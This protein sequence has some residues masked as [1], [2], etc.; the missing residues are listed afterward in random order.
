MAS[1]MFVDDGS[2]T[3]DTKGEWVPRTLKSAPIWA[4]PPRPKAVFKFFFGFPGYLWPLGQ[5]AYW[6]LA[7]VTWLFLQPGADELSSFS[8]LRGS[9]IVPM[10]ARNVVLLLVIAGV[11]H[12]RLYWQRGQGTRFK[13]NTQWPNKKS[14]AFLFGNQVWDNMFWSVVSGAGIWTIYE[15]LM[16]WAYGNGWAPL[17][18]LRTN[19]VWFIALLPLLALWS[20][21]HFYWTHRITHWKPLYKAAHYLHHR[22]VN[23]GPWSGLSMHP[24]EHIIYF[25]RWL[26]LL[27]VPAHPIHLLYLMQRAALAPAYGHTGFDQ[28]V[29][30]ADGETSLSIDSFFHYLHHRYF[31]CNYGNSILPLDHWFGT[32]HDATPESHAQMRQKRR[33]PA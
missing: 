5:A 21:F 13:Y 18:D 29:L 4:W 17:M 2:N 28:L 12:L 8:Q 14:N 3:R 31:E 11:W 30:S 22:N 33:I 7:I 19:P 1:Q 16:L 32:F 20:D 24:I 15:V 6:G 26:L 23:V 25:S 27:L 9:W 10:Y